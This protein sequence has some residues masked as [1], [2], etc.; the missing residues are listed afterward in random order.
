[1]SR[2]FFG[3]SGVLV[4]IGWLAGMFKGDTSFASMSLIVA[5]LALG[6]W[7]TLRKLDVLFEALGIEDPRG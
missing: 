6:F 7:A 5:M 2:A 4:G 3:V 1:M